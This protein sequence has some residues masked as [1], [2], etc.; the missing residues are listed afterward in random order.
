MWECGLR[1]AFQTWLYSIQSGYA[2]GSTFGPHFRKCSSQSGCKISS[3]LCN[4]RYRLAIFNYLTYINHWCWL[5]HKCKTKDPA[6]NLEIPIIP[7]G[8]HSEFGA[9]AN[10]QMVTRY[11][12]FP[13]LA[14]YLFGPLLKSNLSSG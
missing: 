3:P 5:L 9:C 11:L 14:D 13:A 4:K 1:E 12:Y 8:Q 7:P 6:N 2:V 10:H